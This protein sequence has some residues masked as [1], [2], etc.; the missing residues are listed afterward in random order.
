MAFSGNYMCTSFKKEL[1]YGVH[2]FDLANGDTFKIALY[3]N[4]ASFD[5]AT[6]AY[7][8]SNEVSGTGYSAGG[9]ALTNVDPTSSGTTA[10]T[11]FQ[12]ETFSTATITARG[13]LIYNTTPNTTSISVTNPSVVVLD[14]GS[15]KTSTAGDFT[16]V[17][18]TADASNAIIRIA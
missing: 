7:T 13:A 1:L 8:T 15:D 9:G 2:D 5:A 18:P 17:F 6:T 11:D 16:I 10:L 14:F 12:D 4:S 3:D